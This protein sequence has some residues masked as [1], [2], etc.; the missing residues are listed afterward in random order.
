MR[1][2]V[3]ASGSGGNAVWLEATGE[4]LLVDAGLSSEAL[5]RRAQELGHRPAALRAVL[6]THEHDD[7]ARGA[8]ALS[9]TL[10]VPVLANEATLR[11]CGVEPSRAEPFRNLQP[12]RVGPWSVEAVPV[13]HDAADPV[14]FVLEACGV[15]VVVAT[16]LGDVGEPLVERGAGSHVILLEANY[17]LRLLG[18]SPYPWF[19]KNRILSRTGHLSN[20]GAA[21]AAV[22]LHAGRPQQF[23]LVHV[24]EVNNLAPLAR[25][26]VAEALARR[27]IAAGVQVVRPNQGARV[28]LPWEVGRR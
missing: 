22:R 27:G 13:R 26:T 20:D 16:D 17:D 14:A 10:G 23:V 15:R 18:V 6:L 1:I 3:L 9:R 19:V 25:D 11:A 21:S 5:L 7:H 8:A 2:S 12:F 24:S 28:P 4:A